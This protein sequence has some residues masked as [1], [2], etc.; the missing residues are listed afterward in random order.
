MRKLRE[1]TPRQVDDLKTVRYLLSQA[2]SLAVGVGATRLYAK[3]SSALDSADGAVRH[4]ERCLST[5]KRPA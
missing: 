4:A 5:H 3:V 2:C 1:V